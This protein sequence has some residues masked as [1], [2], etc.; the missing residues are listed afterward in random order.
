MFVGAEACFRKEVKWKL[1][2]C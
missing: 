2:V 1:G